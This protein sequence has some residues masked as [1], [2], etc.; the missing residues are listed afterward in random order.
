MHHTVLISGVDTAQE[1]FVP[2][3]T[4][5]KTS[6]CASDGF[7]LLSS[8]VGDEGIAKFRSSISR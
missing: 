1:G 8:R 3:Q 5:L 4:R 2:S 7:P 6:L